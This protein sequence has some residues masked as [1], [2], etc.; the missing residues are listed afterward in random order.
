MP[1]MNR[2]MRILALLF[3]IT[4]CAVNIFASVAISTAGSLPSG[5]VSVPYSATLT[6]TGGTAPYKWS[7]A[8]CSG[9]CNTGLSCP[10]FATTGVLCGTPANAGTSTFGFKV[11]DAAGNTASK[12]L[13]ITI[14][15]STTST[16]AVSVSPASSAINT[17]VSEQFTASVSNTTNTAVT[18][19]VNGTQGGNSTVGTI[20]TAG[21]YKA[22]A[23]GPSGGSV[24]V[25]ATSVAD[26]T[27]S[28][29]GTVVISAAQ[30]PVTVSIT[31]TSSSLTTG[32]SQQF[33]ASVSGTT[34][35]GVIWQVDGVTGGNATYGT[36]SSS[37][38]YTAPAT[39]PSSG[40]A[41]VT[42]V[43]SYQSSASAS[44]T[45]SISAAA[46]KS[47]G[48]SWSGWNF[49]PT[50][51]ASPSGSGSSCTSSAPCSIS[52][53]AANAHAG[54]VWQFAPGKYPV[55]SGVGFSSSGTASSPIIWTCATVRGCSIQGSSG[56]ANVI[57]ISGSYV[58]IDGFDITQNDIAG[59]TDQIVWMT[60]SHVTMSRNSLHD[61]QPACSSNGG[62][63]VQVALGSGGYDTFDANLI[64]NIGNQVAGCKSYNQYDGIIAEQGGNVGAV[65][66]TNN[67]IYNVHGGGGINLG[68]AGGT[69]ANNLIFGNGEWGVV[70]INGTSGKATVTNNIVVDNG[71]DNGDGGIYGLEGTASLVTVANNNL[72]GNNG[73]DFN[74]YTEV[75]SFSSTGT[76]GYNPA[77]GMFINWQSNGSGNYQETAGSPTIGAGTSTGAPNHD[78][79]GNVR[80]GSIDIGP[81]QYQ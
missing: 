25:K 48:G 80:S 81:Y 74:Y 76:I 55:G 37:G 53:A 26:T 16:V 12:S 27:K 54:D 11:T 20:S 47:S 66:I 9:S 58:T 6:A 35:T 73:G 22:P 51:Y 50:K 39:V 77:S 23:S 1:P 69:V 67:I 56:T 5:T 75:G 34:S 15:T 63:G 31:P 49:T 29:S 72:Y 4:L 60:G 24:T 8:S 38:L 7:V 18:W 43:S 71:V 2:T 42:A 33:S 52:Y 61:S 10:T 17:G 59:G 64:Y 36:V 28:A 65:T 30:A 21:L 78:F 44:A 19:S 57:G 14:A 32:K 13:S 3:M 40:S 41:T 46:S 45:V 79:A 70:V 62:G 68:N